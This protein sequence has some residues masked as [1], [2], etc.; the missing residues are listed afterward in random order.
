MMKE[1][2]CCYGITTSFVVLAAN[3]FSAPAVCSVAGEEP[4]RRCFRF[5]VAY[6]SVA[7]ISVLLFQLQSSPQTMDK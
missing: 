6:G 4:D 7:S 1:K 2:K 5:H 3:L